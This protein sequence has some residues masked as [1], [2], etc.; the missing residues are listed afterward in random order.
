[1]KRIRNNGFQH[2]VIAFDRSTKKLFPWR[3]HN[4]V[5]VEA[6]AA[7]AAVAAAGILLPPPE[8]FAADADGAE[9]TW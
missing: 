8:L 3:Q 5:A 2:I 6:A 1:M 7:A 4:P 9:Y